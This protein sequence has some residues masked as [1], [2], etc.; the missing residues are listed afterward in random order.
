MLVAFCAI[1]LAACGEIANGNN[2]DSK[3]GETTGTVVTAG[4]ETKTIDVS[5]FVFEHVGNGY[6]LKSYTGTDSTI[7]VPSKYNGK[8]VYLIKAGAFAYGNE[9]KTINISDTVVEIEDGAFYCCSALN[10]VTIPDNVKIMSKD[11]FFNSDAIQTANISANLTDCIPKTELQTVV[12]TGGE[13]IKDS[14]FYNCQKLKSITIPNS[15]TSIGSSAFYN[16]DSLISVTIG[17]SVT[18]IGSHAFCYC[19]LLT[20]LKFNG[21]KAQWNGISKGY[22][23]NYNSAI[24]QVVCTDGTINL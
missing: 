5:D 4:G 8:K 1:G 20:S 3:N 19:S 7:N 15:V 10:S 14:A 9:F 17:N 2:A 22:S 23:W 6:A 12:I 21:T 11:A 13:S 24:T 18:S 16:C